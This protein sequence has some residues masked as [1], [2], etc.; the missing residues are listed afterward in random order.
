MSGTR[1]NC[2]ELFGF[3]SVLVFIP[4]CTEAKSSA[5]HTPIL[6]A[7]HMEIALEALRISHFILCIITLPTFPYGRLAFS[8]CPSCVRLKLVKSKECM[9]RRLCLASHCAG[10]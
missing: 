1:G 6:R 7:V 3:F 4:H 10:I 5:T 8:S 2:A 9:G